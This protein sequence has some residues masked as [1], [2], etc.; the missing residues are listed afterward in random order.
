MY[1]LTGAGMTQDTPDA[2]YSITGAGVSFTATGAMYSTTSA[3]VPQDAAGAMN[4]TLGT[5]DV[6]H[7]GLKDFIGC[8]G[9]WCNVLYDLRTVQDPRPLQTQT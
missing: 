4:S 1:S 3:A 6:F 8:G 2:M 5:C 9:S 7:D